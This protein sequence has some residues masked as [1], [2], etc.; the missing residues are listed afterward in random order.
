MGYTRSDSNMG[1]DVAVERLVRDAEGTSGLLLAQCKP[2]RVL[3]GDGW[4][5]GL[6][7]PA[8]RG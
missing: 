4:K 8:G 2:R 1:L 7:S 6:L 5:A 3:R